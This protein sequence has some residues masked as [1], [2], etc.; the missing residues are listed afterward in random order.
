MDPYKPWQCGHGEGYQFISSKNKIQKYV[1]KVYRK[2][3]LAQLIDHNTEEADGSDQVT[4]FYQ[5][6]TVTG[7]ITAA[8]PL[9]TP[10][11]LGVQPE[12]AEIVYTPGTV[13]AKEQP[14]GRGG[15]PEFLLEKM[16]HFQHQNNVPIHLKGG[17]ID[18]VLFGSTLVMCAVGFAGCLHF[19]YGMAFPKKSVD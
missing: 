2:A 9:Q 10:T 12:G 4:M 11:K 19:F 13:F 17:P 5:K 7:R 6:N 8:P 16:R 14:R 18:K 15:I 1:R 3:V